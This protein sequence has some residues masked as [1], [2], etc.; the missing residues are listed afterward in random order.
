MSSAAEQ[1]EEVVLEEGVNESSDE[2]ELDFDEEDQQWL[3]PCKCLYCDEV[4]T[5]VL[6]H[7]AE[8]HGFDFVAQCRSRSDVANEYDAIRLV[9]IT[10]R[11]VRD[12]MCPF[13]HGSVAEDALARSE[14]CAAD[15]KSK[16]GLLEAHF[17]AYPEH[18]LPSSLGREAAEEELV[19][20]LPGDT[21]LSLLVSNSEGFFAADEEE[22]DYAM[23]PT[24]RELGTKKAN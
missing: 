7:M 23:I 22:I 9:N 4:S 1:D 10:R 24:G 20:T 17:E 11:Y 16:G 6:K 3:E 14:S 21:L 2:A 19:P 18:R 5:A 12:G 8:A 15:V 13:V